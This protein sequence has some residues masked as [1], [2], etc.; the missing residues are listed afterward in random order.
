[1]HPVWQS[2]LFEAP[3]SLR[4]TYND[5][6][7]YRTAESTDHEQVSSSKSVDQEEEPDERH[8]GLDHTEDASG[9]ERSVRT[10]NADRGEDGRA[11][12]VDCVDA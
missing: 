9:Q 8:D 11:V 10:A 2:D 4:D 5:P 1:M 7:A 6:H 3:N 12:V